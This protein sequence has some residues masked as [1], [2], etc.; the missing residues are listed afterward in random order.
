MK[1]CSKLSLTQ[2]LIHSQLVKVVRGLENYDVYDLI[3]K[4]FYY[5]I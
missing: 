3:F 4:Y 5:I 2:H 1:Y